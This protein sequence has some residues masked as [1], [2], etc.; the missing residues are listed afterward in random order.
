MPEHVSIRTGSRLHFGLLTQQPASGREFGGLGVM[1]AQPGWHI[2]A[3]RCST[4]HVEVAPQAALVNPS[5]EK[6]ALE[7]LSRAAR[8]TGASGFQIRILEAVE[9]HQGL[10]SGTQLGLAIAKAAALLTGLDAPIDVLAQRV[11]RGRR[12]AI[13]IW[14]FE[15][16]GFIVDGGKLDTAA[17]GSLVARIDMPPHWCFVLVT[18]VT[19]SGLSGSAEIAAFAALPSMPTNTTARLCQLS[20]MTILP[21]LRDQAFPEFAAGLYEYGQLVGEYFSQVQGGV[22][23]SRTM[24]HVA[25]ALKDAQLAGPVQTSWGPTCAIPCPDMNVANHVI[26]VVKSNSPA[27]ELQLR[28]VQP[29]NTAAE[30][31]V[32]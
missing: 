3:E 26:N 29:F 30:I 16:G 20:L 9:G 31:Q 21:A 7:F 25:A 4:S 5:S 13:G 6:R 12:S 18:P 24:G 19:E 15:A 32:S 1:I 22:F 27:A 2:T 14:G 17:I 28:I 10:G 11:D 23:S 8:S